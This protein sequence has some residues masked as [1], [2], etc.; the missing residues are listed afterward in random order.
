MYEIVPL[1]SKK[2]K[3]MKDK[4]V[5]NR[6]TYLISDMRRA[7][8]KIGV[9]QPTTLV[10]EFKNGESKE[11]SIGTA[12]TPP[13]LNVLMTSGLVDTVCQDVRMSTQQWVTTINILI[14]MKD[15]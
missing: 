7:S 1:E 13:H 14:A 4:F 12:S 2:G 15:K 5:F 6:Q 11:F 3:L 8:L 9:F 10:L